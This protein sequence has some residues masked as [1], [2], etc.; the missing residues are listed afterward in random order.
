MSNKQ[1]AILHSIR[2]IARETNGLINAIASEFG[3]K[4]IWQQDYS[5][6]IIDRKEKYAIHFRRRGNKYADWL[7]LWSFDL[8]IMQK[9]KDA[10]PDDFKTDLVIK[11]EYGYD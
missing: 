9:I 5:Y 10:F 1:M 2:H 3:D 6:N 11:D 8:D 4:I 7:E